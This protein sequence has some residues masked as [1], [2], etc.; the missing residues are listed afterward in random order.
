MNPS[1]YHLGLV[2]AKLYTESDSQHR[3]LSLAVVH[4]CIILP[5]TTEIEAF[6]A[7]F[8]PRTRTLG[9]R[10][11]DEEYLALER[12]CIEN[13]ARSIS[14]LARTAICSFVSRSNQEGILAATVNDMVA[15]VEELQGKIE[16]LSAEI[17]SFPTNASPYPDSE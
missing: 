8:I 5:R 4:K 6:V 17:S 10:L 11:S 14:D 1:P 15:H 9:V 12:F 13:G 2:L 7:V 3:Y 16:K